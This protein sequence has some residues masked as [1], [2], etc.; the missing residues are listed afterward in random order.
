MHKKTGGQ[1]R[2][3][4]WHSKSHCRTCTTLGCSPCLLYIHSIFGIL[5]PVLCQAWLQALGT[6]LWANLVDKVVWKH[7]HCK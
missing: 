4:G 1:S 6:E 2:K 5:V 7:K 3:E